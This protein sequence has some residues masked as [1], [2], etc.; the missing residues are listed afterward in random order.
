MVQH[1]GFQI[2]SLVFQVTSL[3]FRLKAWFERL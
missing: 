2:T 1:L 3:V